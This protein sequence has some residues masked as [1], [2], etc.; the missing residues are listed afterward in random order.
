MSA[1]C[2]CCWNDYNRSIRRTPCLMVCGP[3][4]MMHY[5]AIAAMQRGMTKGPIWL[6]LERNMQCAVGMCGHC[7]LGPAFICK[8]GPVFRYDKIEPFLQVQYL[9][10]RRPDEHQT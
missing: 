2:R 10:V 6:S 3:E 5:T 1:P 9:L 4:V 8:D 7:Q